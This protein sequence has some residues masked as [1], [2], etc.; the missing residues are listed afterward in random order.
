MGQTTQFEHNVQA[1]IRQERLVGQGEALLVALSGGADSVA[2]LRVL[3]R[4]GYSC[5]AAHCNF[6][7]R[8]EESNRDEAFCRTLCQTLGV[9]LHVTH[10]DTHE[11]AARQGISIEMAA[12]ELRYAWFDELCSG[13]GYAHVAVAHHRDDA[14]ETLLLN[15]VRG[16]GLAGLT[17]I[18]P[19]NGRV[20]RPLLGVSRAEVMAYL[21][22]LAQ[23]YV[24]DSTNLQ[25]EYVRNKIRLQIL[26]L[27]EKIN[28]QV[29]E[30]I[31]STIHHLRGVETIYDK[32]VKEAVARVADVDGRTINIPALLGEVEPQTVLF[33]LLRPYGFVSAQ[34]ED[35]F[36]SLT[37]ESGRRFAN[38][39][40][41]VLKDRDTLILRP[42]QSESELEEE[43]IGISIPQP[44]VEVALTRESMLLVSRFPLAPDYRISR[45]PK[46]A[47]LDASCVEFPLTVRPW[48]QG[49][50]FAPFG[51]KGR[52]KLVSDLLT[53]LKLSRFEKEKQLVVTD[54]RDRILWVVGRRTD[55]RARVTEQTREVVEMIVSYI[56]RS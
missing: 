9:E 35:V 5:H 53:D 47:T 24:T 16:T 39:G 43:R 50:K 32:A 44:P 41:E 17:G 22:A 19:V 42:R 18:R 25:D 8:G 26:P 4:L 40:W 27:L 34:V 37:G 6:H 12:R 51:M 31:S 2:L 38:G 29:R 21:K 36:R 54:A 7:L 52:K 11:Y 49:D 56:Y 46:V 3:L 55:E 20:V 14:V 33:E 23:D 1:F 28:P 10:F 13:H 30:K 45:S 48:R 15:L